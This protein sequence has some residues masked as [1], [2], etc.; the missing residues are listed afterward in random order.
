MKFFLKIFL[1]SIGQ[2]VSNPVPL[3]TPLQNVPGHQDFNT[4]EMPPLLC[5]LPPKR[6]TTI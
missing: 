2:N 3:T 6:Q 1:Q 5:F 4:S